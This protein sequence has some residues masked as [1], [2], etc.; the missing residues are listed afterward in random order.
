MTLVAP[1]DAAPGID[2]GLAGAATSGDLDALLPTL[3]V[4]YLL[5]IQHERQDASRSRRCASTRRASG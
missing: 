4:I 2:D 5:R 3:D 1:A